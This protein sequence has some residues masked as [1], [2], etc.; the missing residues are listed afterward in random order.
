MVGSPWKNLP[1][2]QTDLWKGE[3]GD[4]KWIRVNKWKFSHQSEDLFQ[5]SK[6]K[7][8]PRV[9]AQTTLTWARVCRHEINQRNSIGSNPSGGPMWVTKDDLTDPISVLGGLN[10]QL[11]TRSC[12]R[13]V[14]FEICCCCS[15]QARI[16]AW[17]VRT[18]L[19]D[20]SLLLENYGR[21]L[22]LLLWLWGETNGSKYQYKNQEA[23]AVAHSVGELLNFLVTTHYSSRAFVPTK[24]SYFNNY[25][26]LTQHFQKSPK[27]FNLY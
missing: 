10:C 14:H 3:R 2:M 18:P 23:W 9:Q 16:E 27:I 13:N 12:P 5:A 7:F 17:R 21:S 26:N 4:S 11:L 15:K 22:P 25:P 6:W 1:S 24:V 19:L 8:S 20:P